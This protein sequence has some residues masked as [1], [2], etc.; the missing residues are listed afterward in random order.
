MAFQQG[1]SGLGASA[2]QL[3]VISNNVANAT[4]V[5][6]KSG[7][8]HFADV[9]AA[10]LNGAGASQIGV[11]VSVAAIAQ[12]FTQGNISTTNNPLDIGI[13]G[14]GFFRMEN[15]SGSFSYTR[16][17]QFHLDKEGYVVND[18]TAKLTGYPVDAV[19][20]VVIPSAP[21]PIKLSADDIKPIATGAGTGSLQG[22]QAKVNLDSR[23]AATT[24]VNDPLPGIQGA[25]TT[26]AWSPNV[27]T[28]NFST[29]GTVYDTLGN[30][31]NLVLYYSK[32]A[33]AGEWEVHANVDGTSD[34]N[35][36]LT[37]AVP[38][39]QF[40]KWGVLDPNVVDNG[41]INVS[42]NLDQVMTD[43]GKPNNAVAPLAFD[44]DMA[45]SSQY[46]EASANN[47]FN[48]DGSA[49]GH[50]TGMSVA[51]DGIV[52]GNYSNGQS[53]SLAQVVLA[54][55]ANPNGL[56]SLGNNQWQDTATS[57]PELVGAPN[58][59]RLGVLQSAS[60]EESNVDLTAE[61]VAMITAQRS[62]QA[63]AQSIK[64]QD[65]IMQTLVNLR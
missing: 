1:L 59:G 5:G 56:L 35:V 62:Y 17:G 28:Y 12:Q 48:Q 11:G 45:G 22:V 23:L 33:N 9:F 50:L 65:Q 34:A 41:K 15:S 52:K 27:G 47:G 42:I 30:P 10:S 31:H 57:G 53:L 19:T 13:N 64:T 32:T 26:G 18:Q 58:S 25:E 4:T 43:L 36:T 60:V 14:G 8:T 24:W 63:N 44:L 2:K 7:Q 55:F 61:L 21:G 3:D 51:A 54:N 6:F 16:S 39:L 29:P 20:G 37:P 49:A 46:G 40:N 38:L